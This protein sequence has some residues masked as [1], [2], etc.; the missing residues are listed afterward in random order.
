MFTHRANKPAKYFGFQ[1]AK[2]SNAAGA[3]GPRFSAAQ[4]K[5][6]HGNRRIPGTFNQPRKKPLSVAGCQKVDFVEQGIT[7]PDS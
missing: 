4:M 2:H 3:Q 5:A 1:P 6:M 7:R